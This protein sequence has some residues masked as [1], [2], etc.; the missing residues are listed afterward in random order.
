[1]SIIPGGDD[2]PIYQGGFDC[3]GEEARLINCPPPSDAPQTP[4]VHANDLILQ[5]NTNSRLAVSVMVCVC[6]CQRIMLQCRAM[7]G[8]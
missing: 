7:K 4:C 6:V 8:T 3:S 5:C 1:M 2:V